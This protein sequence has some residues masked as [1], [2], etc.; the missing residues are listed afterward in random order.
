[1][2]KYLRKCFTNI[3]HSNNCYIYIDKDFPSGSDCKE[4][5]C[6]VGDPGSI[7]G[8]GK[9]PWRR[10]WLPTPVFLPGKSH[11]QN[12]S[13]GPWGR[14]ESDP[15][16]RLTYTDFTYTDSARFCA[17]MMTAWLC[18]DHPFL[19]LF[20]SICS[21]SLSWKLSKWPTPPF[22][23]HHPSSGYLH[24]LR[25][26]PHSL[27]ASLLLS[28][29]NHSWRWNSRHVLKTQLLWLP[30]LNSYRGFLMVNWR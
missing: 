3:W 9:V 27:C 22:R 5:V 12:G 24:L 8:S 6:N 20:A 7:E 1:M 2:V 13:Y 23:G 15:T 10:E 30:Y 18:F 28:P 14:K 29:P 17:Q 19:L 4:S 11:G 25:V 21:H 16:E 26:G